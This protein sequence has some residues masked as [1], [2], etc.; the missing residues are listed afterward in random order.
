[1]HLTNLALKG[2]TVFRPWEV[3]ASGFSRKWINEACLLLWQVR[4][5][6]A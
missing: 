4:S 2:F 6:K 5:L 3:S 1:M